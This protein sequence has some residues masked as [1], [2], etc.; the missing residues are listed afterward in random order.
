MQ[1]IK[2]QRLNLLITKY[3]ISFNFSLKKHALAFYLSW[4]EPDSEELVPSSQGEWAKTELR[5]MA[6]EICHR[7][8]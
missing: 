5:S 1:F 2:S 6:E 3:L 7:Y 8:W 4:L